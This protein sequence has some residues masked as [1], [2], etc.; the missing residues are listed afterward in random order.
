MENIEF[1]QNLNFGNIYQLKISLLRKLVL[2]RKFSQKNAYSEKSMLYSQH[3]YLIS[4][5]LC[6]DRL[7]KISKFVL[8]EMSIK[9]EKVRK[10][11]NM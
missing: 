8:T 3:S 2:W 5:E 4:F 10:N 1:F 7:K 6:K 9:I 11:V